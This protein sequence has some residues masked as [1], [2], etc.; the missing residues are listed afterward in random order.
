MDLNAFFISLAVSVASDHAANG[1]QVPFY[2]GVA[3]TSK[4]MCVIGRSWVQQCGLT[5]PWGFWSW[6]VDKHCV[7]VDKLITRQLLSRGVKNRRVCKEQRT[8]RQALQ[9]WNPLHA[10][11][12]FVL[13]KKKVSATKERTRICVLGS[14]ESNWTARHYSCALSWTALFW[15]Y[16]SR[17][18]SL[19]MRCV[20][21]CYALGGTFSSNGNSTASNYT[22]I[23]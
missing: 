18:A 23:H 20:F 14:L 16:C 4:T 17:C 12:T 7:T 22:L 15:R 6:I 11:G 21:W 10:V 1:T 8:L 5:S 19:F 9:A 13:H 3:K 2:V